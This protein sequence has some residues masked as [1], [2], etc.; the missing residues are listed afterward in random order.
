MR[1][2]L[3]EFDKTLLIRTSL[4]GSNVTT[5]L[6]LLRNYYYGTTADLLL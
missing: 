4:Q 1:Y 6:L 5:K 2:I 3:V